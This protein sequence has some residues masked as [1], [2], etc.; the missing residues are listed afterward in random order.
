[1]HGNAGQ[2]EGGTDSD[3]RYD[4]EDGTEL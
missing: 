1:L 3:A 4:L 2:G